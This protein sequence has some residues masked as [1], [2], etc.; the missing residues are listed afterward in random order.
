MQVAEKTIEKFDEIRKN[1]HAYA[2]QWKKRTG[3]KVVGCF[4]SYVPEEILYAAGILPVRILGGHEVQELTERHIFGHYCPFSRDCLAQGLTG[5]Y[6]YVDGIAI[7]HCCLHMRQPFDT[8]RRHIPTAWNHFLYMPEM[9][10]SPHSRDCF[11]QDVGQFKASLE[12]WIGQ[13]ISDK[14]LDNA[15][16]IYN[17]NRRLLREVFELRKSDPPALSGV[18]A[19]NMAITSMYVDKA[20]HNQ[21]LE[22]ALSELRKRERKGDHKVRLMVIGSE[23]DVEFIRL[24]EKFGPAV[25]IDDLC[26]GTRNF[27]NDV[28]PGNDRIRAIANRYMDRPPCPLRDMPERRRIPYILKLAKDYKVEGAIIALQKFCEPHALDRPSIEAALKDN[29]VPSMYLELDVTVAEG[30]IRTR[31]EAFL[32]ML[33]LQI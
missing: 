20:E 22:A 29:G 30:Q 4:C 23:A 25:V 7:T 10:Q 8:W 17:K 19:M 3:G 16:E 28:V 12:K 21:M 9:A 33:E 1:R 27:W 24:V 15:I 11:A 13:P 32:E 26:T 18:E 2:E 31:I 14:A 6:K 5:A